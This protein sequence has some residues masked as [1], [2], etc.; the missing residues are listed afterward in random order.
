MINRSL[1][2]ATQRAL[3]PHIQHTQELIERAVSELNSGN[4]GAEITIMPDLGI[5]SNLIRMNGGFFTGMFI[6]WESQVPFI[7]VDTTVNGCGVSVYLLNDI[8][9]NEEF[10]KR[11]KYAKKR[12]LEFSYNWNFERGNHFISYG[13]TDSG[14]PCAVFHASADEFKHSAENHS[15]YPE[16]NV[17]YTD[18]IKTIQSDSGRYLRYISGASAEKFSAVAA[19]LSQINER[20]TD[21]SAELVFGN[22]LKEKR[23]YISHY[24]MPDDHSVAIGCSWLK[25]TYVLLTAMGKDIYLVDPD[26]KNSASKYVLN[27]HGF[28]VELASP[29]DISYQPCGE[30]HL[31]GVSISDKTQILAT[32]IQCVRGSSSNAGQIR[33]HINRILKLCPGII[34][35][36]IHQRASISSAGA[37]EFQG[38]TTINKQ[39]IHL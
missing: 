4:G 12:F 9:T 23:L 1:N 3:I 20:R 15:L 33:E 6:N 34:S 35:R 29:C 32:N 11:I 13:I 8:M 17:W 19:D 16:K 21:T 18:D 5:S 31:N 36:I 30:L 22:C 27:P 7:P 10:F 39:E 37:F 28:G 38:N 14:E 26:L 2:D 24:G 25:G